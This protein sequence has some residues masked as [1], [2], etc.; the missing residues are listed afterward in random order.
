MKNQQI[1]KDNEWPPQFQLLPVPR[2]S[3]TRDTANIDTKMAPPKSPVIYAQSRAS[4]GSR[5]HSRSRSVYPHSRNSS[6]LALFPTSP[7]LG[8]QGASSRNSSRPPL[9]SRKSGNRIKRKTSSHALTPDDE[10]PSCSI[11]IDNRL[12]QDYFQQD[13]LEAILT[14]RIPKWKSVDMSQ[15][16]ELTI[17][18]ISGALT[19]AVYSVSP[20]Q[21]GGYGYKKPPKLLLRVYGSQAEQ[22]INRDEELDILSRLAKQKIGPRL[23]GIFANG[24]FEQF[25]EATTLTKDDLRNP[26]ISI[27]IARRMREL[28]DGIELTDFER[29]NGAAVLKNIKNWIPLVEEILPTL[30]NLNQNNL[31][32][33]NDFKQLKLMIFE[34]E[35][36]LINK[37]GGL[38]QIKTDLRF[39]HNDTQYGNLMKIRP[40][41]GSPLIAAKH[42]H[43]QLVVI[44]F[45]YSGANMPGYD[46]AN[47]FNEW[48]SDYHSEENQHDIHIDK[49]PTIDEQISWIKGYVL[50]GTN[51]RDLKE[52]ENFS[53]DSPA[54]ISSNQDNYKFA[55][56]NLT[57]IKKEI[58]RIYL[59][60]LFWRPINHIQ[61]CLW[62]IIQAIDNHKID[63]VMDTDRY[64]VS[65]DANGDLNESSSSEI[66][67]KN[68]KSNINLTTLN[69]GNINDLSTKLHDLSLT[70]TNSLD[71][72]IEIEEESISD[73]DYINYSKQKCQL[74]WSDLINLG[75][76][77]AKE[78]Y[79]G[80]I[81]KLP[82]D[83][84]LKL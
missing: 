3:S 61:W 54:P 72:E 58:K 65:T 43:R 79:N 6:Q 14:L 49:F 8:P 82:T 75:F 59:E 40:P 7:Q 5:S 76:K 52:F 15:A 17:D 12:P 38:D 62:G 41:S 34:Y 66:K 74:F 35:N 44:D 60:T 33:C 53:L 36:F 42:S 2:P 30:S 73:F 57:E 46:I 64:I 23:L 1:Y 51:V 39:C 80:D 10:I 81:K 4:S 55:S 27:Q 56:D 47:H 16:P 13:V 69:N 11:I 31:I 48:M 78:F 83:L 68:E 22:L 28:H 24:R 29:S 37:F 9:I 67:N 50:E 21:Y 19:N 70:Q 25:L 18:R 20:P 84:D 32:C 77:N 45:E 63:D 26:K 71:D